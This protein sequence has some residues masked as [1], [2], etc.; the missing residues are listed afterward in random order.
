MSRGAL[1]DVV[2]VKAF[3]WLLYANKAL[4]AMVFADSRIVMYVF[5]FVLWGE[6]GRAKIGFQEVRDGNES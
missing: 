1:L 5:F 4:K 6:K 2:V 3:T